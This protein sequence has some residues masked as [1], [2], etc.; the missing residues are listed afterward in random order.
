MVNIERIDYNNLDSK[1]LNIIEKERVISS[2]QKKGIVEFDNLPW[3]KNEIQDFTNYFTEKYS[4]D[5]VRRS[6]KYEKT[7]INSVDAGSTKIP[8]HSEASFSYAYPEIIWFYC[9]ENDEKGS[10]T[11]I[12]DGAELWK[13][14]EKST[15]EFFLKNPITYTVAIDIPYKIKRKGQEKFFIEYPGVSDSLI[16]WELGKIMFNYSKFVINIDRKFD[17]I[18]FANHLLVGKDNEEQIKKITTNNNNSIPE[19]IMKEINIKS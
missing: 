4:S 1:S 13:N 3:E 2:F 10:P 12:C 6:K 7:N 5:A 19:D 9:Y 14:L 16:D 11:T 8:L 18:W 15:K 17:K